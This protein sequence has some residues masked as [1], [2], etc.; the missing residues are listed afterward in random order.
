[1]NK[2]MIGAVA[3]AVG[4]SASVLINGAGTILA[5]HKASQDHLDNL[6]L[7]QPLT[8]A[9]GMGP[10]QALP[11]GAL[12][13]DATPEPGFIPEAGSTKLQI[14]LKPGSSFINDK[15]RPMARLVLVKSKEFVR[16]TKDPIW[17]LR[18]MAGDQIL[19]S[20]PALTGRANKQTADRN[21]P[22]NKAPLPK[23]TYGIDAYG[24]A[25]PPF[26][27]SEL[28][29]GFWVPIV[30]LFSTRRSDL[31]FHQDPSWGK[32]NGES[33]TSGCIGLESADATA[34]L[35]EWIKHFRIKTLTVET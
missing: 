15:G 1:M 8:Q 27:D 7:E 18:L 28:G 16:G 32:M 30:P 14:Q 19:G 35:V 17:D 2:V 4:V 26:S 25:G 9:Q 29:K 20:M 5:H 21:T 22:G 10:A 3:A 24:I 33:G 12:P 11:P 31:G 13:L 23:G 6:M 34:K